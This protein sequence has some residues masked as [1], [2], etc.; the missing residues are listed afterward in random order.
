MAKRKSIIPRPLSMR[1][2]RNLSAKSR[3]PTPSSAL[4]ALLAS[5]AGSVNT[6]PVA[7]HELDAP[8]PSFLCPSLLPRAEFP[9]LPVPPQTPPPSSPVP[10]PS[11]VVHTDYPSPTPE[12]HAP[13]ELA[14]GYTQGTDGR[15]RKLSTWSLYG[16]T[17]CVCHDASNTAATQPMDDLASTPT[18]PPPNE[19]D[20]LPPGWT[21]MSDNDSARTILILA[22]SLV[23]AALIAVF[24]FFLI[25]RRNHKQR[26]K[27]D[28]EKKL[29]KKKGSQQD[30]DTEKEHRTKVK[31]W[32]RATT[33]WKENIRHSARRRRNARLSNTSLHA[34][35]NSVFSSSRT[36]SSTHS[37]PRSTPASL[38][39]S[40]ASSP[41][42]TP[43]TTR[44]VRSSSSR[45]DHERQNIHVQ[46]PSPSPPSPPP[47][48]PAYQRRSRLSVDVPSVKNIAQLSS[49]SSLYGSHLSHVDSHSSE[50]PPS[51]PLEGEMSL[52][53]LHIAHVATD[54]KA[55]LQQIEDMG[56]QPP[57]EPGSSDV[58]G[59]A[60]ILYEDDIQS[61]KYGDLPE[62]EPSSVGFPLP[63]TLVSSS[64]GK[65]AALEYYDY[66]DLSV[67]SYPQPSAPPFGADD[68]IL[69]SAPPEGEA[70]PLPSAPPEIADPD[71]GPTADAGL[72]GEMGGR[73]V[74]PGRL[75]PSRTEPLPQYQP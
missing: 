29:V 33:R 12:G 67:E 38:P 59:S 63:P 5:L 74:D 4:L 75:G 58:Y 13:R 61:L 64:K 45:T 57:P 15:W 34:S 17:I 26:E 16:S 53:N 3:T 65:A 68:V 25:W 44:S 66:D 55:V 32:A 22:F 30:V 18:P 54:E 7:C 28:L 41:T 27:I 20:L 69:P 35:N 56:S 37:S 73:S 46:P 50:S 1:L 71:D 62:L 2:L 43:S 72:L 19:T 8:P 14:P 10:G 36:N 60:P 23:L 6:F 24:I 47:L 49:G 52:S 42:P 39:P 31:L 21:R 11:R 48:P 40:R 51:S 70:Q 9:G